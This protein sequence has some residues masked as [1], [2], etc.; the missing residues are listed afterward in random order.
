[1]LEEQERKKKTTQRKK[2]VERMYFYLFVSGGGYILFSLCIH[3][4]SP[5]LRYKKHNNK[6]PSC[7]SLKMQWTNQCLGALVDRDAF[8]RYFNAWARSF[9]HLFKNSSVFFSQ[10]GSLFSSK[11][12]PLVNHLFL[13]VKS[14]SITSLAYKRGY[15][16]LQ[17]LSGLISTQANEH[18]GKLVWSRR[19]IL[20]ACLATG[21]RQP[22]LAP[23][24]KFRNEFK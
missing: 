24:L 1:M 10:T 14:N 11:K 17:T 23:T 15:V 22:P 2:E 9:S 7:H 6:W 8:F 4:P 21:V 20:Y 13:V 18:S 19:W 5:S 12:K 3:V 16:V